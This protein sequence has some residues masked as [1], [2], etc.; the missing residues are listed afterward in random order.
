MIHFF[1]KL[2]LSK[3]LIF[4]TANQVLLFYAFDGSNFT[5]TKADGSVNTAKCTLSD[6][7]LKFIVLSDILLSQ[8][9]KMFLINLNSSITFSHILLSHHKFLKILLKLLNIE[10]IYATARN[11]ICYW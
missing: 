4:F 9:N 6:S 11:M 1:E 7:L 10:D 2:Q 5:W 3:Y 8:L